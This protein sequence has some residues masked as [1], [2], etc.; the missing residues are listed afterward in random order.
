MTIEYTT[1][2]GITSQFSFCGLPFRLDTYSGCNF[3]CSYCFARLRGGNTSSK[4]L[5]IA[6]PEK[7]IKRFKF[8]IKHPDTATG[9]VSEAIRHRLPLHFG[10]M[11]D[12]FQPAEKKSGV[13]LAILKY[14]CEINYPVVISTKSPLV[15]EKEYLDVLKSNPHLVVQY[16]FSSA[17]NEISNYSEPHAPTSSEKLKAISKLSRNGINTTV[18]WQPYI[19]N[20]SEDPSKFVSAIAASGIKHLGLE[21]LKLPIEK[22]NELWRRLSLK[23]DFDINNHYKLSKAN[24]DGREYVLPPEYKIERLKEVKSASNKFGITFGAADNELQYMSDTNC[25]CSGVDQFDG[26]ENWNKYQISHAVKKSG[27]ENITYDRIQKY[28]KPAGSIDKHLNSNSRL[29]KRNNAHNT[30]EDYLLHRWQN[31][32]SPFNPTTFYGVYFNGDKDKSGRKIYK[33]D[34]VKC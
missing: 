9:I 29:P 8:A 15:A 27:F 1:P 28:W 18:R 23:L 30:V 6:D 7:I 5:K 12:P 13:S 17:I 3:N 20:V 11:S 2:I 22:N 33:W 19:P 31:L 26:F 21:H 25:C 14:L 32:D 4:K 10:G 34:K 24:R 16:S